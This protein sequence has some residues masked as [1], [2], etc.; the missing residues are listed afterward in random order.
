MPA[1]SHGMSRDGFYK[2]W[3]NIKTRCYNS[4]IP[5]FKRYGGRGIK[6]CPEWK[7]S[8]EKFYLDMFPSYEKG[9][10]LERINN[11][12]GYSKKNCRW[13]TRAE[14]AMNTRNIDRAARFTFNGSK[15]TV[16]EWASIYG[17][18]RRTLHARL[19][20]NKWPIEKALL[21]RVG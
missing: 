13:A 20:V 8:F 19:C 15:K 16:R 4:T 17:I 6:V 14:Q 5:D 10:T 1:L 9:L 12:K 18:K 2:T 11:D 7:Y 21:E 3:I